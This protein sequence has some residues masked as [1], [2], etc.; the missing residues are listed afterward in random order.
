[1]LPSSKS[2][3][4]PID[5]PQFNVALAV[6]AADS[7]EGNDILQVYDTYHFKNIMLIKNNNK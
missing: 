6:A 4:L 7:T 2:S 3:H 1:M 5:T